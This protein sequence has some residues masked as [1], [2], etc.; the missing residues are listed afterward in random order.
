LLFCDDHNDKFIK[1]DHIP[2]DSQHSA[3]VKVKGQGYQT[4]K[5]HT[6]K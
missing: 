4:S 3:G 6:P 2:L 1:Y 5:Y